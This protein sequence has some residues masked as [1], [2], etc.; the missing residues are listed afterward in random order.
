MNFDVNNK[1][2][3]ICI[4]GKSGSGKTEIA[5]FYEKKAINVIHSYTDRPQRYENEWGHIFIKPEEVDNYRAEMIAYTIF[6]KYH[7]FATKAQY[8]NKGITLYVIDPNGVK[9]LKNKVQ[10]A[11]LVFIYI[12]T[13]EETRR[14]R[15][16][17]REDNEESIKA[18]L[19]HDKEAFKLVECDY[20]IDNNGNFEDAISVLDSILCHQCI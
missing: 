17:L 10:D 3:I 9:A 8:K 6:D 18:R 11:K 16:Q 1:D 7:Y 5:K 4:I 14:G 20:V 19:E 12:N 15:M 13:D 2:V